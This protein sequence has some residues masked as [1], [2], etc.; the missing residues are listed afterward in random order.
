MKK[1]SNEKRNQLIL[2]LVVAVAVLAGIWFGL[3][4]L[5]QEHLQALADRRSEVQAKLD[6][7]QSA[8]KNADRFE[9]EVTEICKRLADLEEDMAPTD[10]YGWMF[11]KIRL[12]KMPY[13]VEIPQIS[14]PVLND[15]NLLPKFPFKQATFTMAGTGHFHDVGKFLADLEN[16]FPYFRVVKLDLAPAPTSTDNEKEKLQ[17]VMDVVTLVKPAT[18]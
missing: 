4:S 1:I 15:V 11:S 14:Q 5:Q 12:F 9:S 13:K 6:K 3:I 16:H 2:V 17:F 8:V 10:P 18:L 7:V